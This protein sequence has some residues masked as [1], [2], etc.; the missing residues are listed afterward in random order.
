MRKAAVMRSVLT[1]TGCPKE[2]RTLKM[3]TT[4]RYGLRALADMCAHMDGKP[5]S[6]GEVARRQDIPPNYLE[7]LFARLRQGGVL[8]SVRGARGGYLLARG[9]GE[10]TIADIAGALG[11]D[12]VF[13]PCQ[14]ERG[15][16]NA[17]L[18]PTFDLWRRVRAAV[19]GILEATTLEDVVSKQAALLASHTPDSLRS[20]VRERALLYEKRG[21]QCKTESR[22]R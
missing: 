22:R 12:V 3:S 14:T 7:Q 17:P 4:T 8:K 21:A 20:E 15:C 13:G 2:L 6:V 19:D 9:A 18:C 1:K 16:V 11:E 10:I 5:V